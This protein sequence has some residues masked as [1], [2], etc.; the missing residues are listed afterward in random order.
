MKRIYVNTRSNQSINN[1]IEYDEFNEIFSQQVKNTYQPGDP[2]LDSTNLG[3]L[4]EPE[5]SIK[6]SRLIEDA[7]I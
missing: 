2:M 5:E 3:P 4:A 7:V 1:T 6:L